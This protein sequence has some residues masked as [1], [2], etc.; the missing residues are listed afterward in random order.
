MDDSL[1]DKIETD[2]DDAL[3]RFKAWFRADKDHS[4]EWRKE[5]EEDFDFVSGRQ[6]ATEE[7]QTLK[8]QNRPSVVRRCPTVRKSVLSRALL[9]TPPLT[10]A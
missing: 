5:A 7:E 3:T 10:S 8:D 4:T 2:E 1:N 9:T 6:W